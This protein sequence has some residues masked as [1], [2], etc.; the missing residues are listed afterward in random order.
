MKIRYQVI[1]SPMLALAVFLSSGCKDANEDGLTKDAADDGKTPVFKTY[2]ERQKWQAEQDAK[3]APA[4]KGK[5]ATPPKS[6]APPPKS[7]EAKPK[8]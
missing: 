5:T 2:G 4:P 1:A 7:E 8:T 6:P 3:K